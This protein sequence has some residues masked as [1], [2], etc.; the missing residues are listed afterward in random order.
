[1][2]ILYQALIAIPSLFKSDLATSRK[3]LV[4][5]W[6][7]CILVA[8]LFAPITKQNRIYCAGY[9][10]EGFDLYTLRFLFEETFLRQE[11]NVRITKNQAVCL[12]IGANIG[13][14]SLYLTWLYPDMQILAIEPDPDTF[15][16]L[17]KNI[18]HN[19]LKNVTAVH[20]A[21]SDT[22]GELV[23]YVHPHIKG[24]LKMSTYARKGMTKEVRVP[25]RRLSDILTEQKITAI[26]FAKIDI[27]GAEWQ[28]LEDLT[29]TGWLPKINQAVI[30]YHHMM[31][32]HES[33]LGAFL[34]PFEAVGFKYQLNTKSLPYNTAPLFQD[35]LIYFYQSA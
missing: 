3:L 13:M 14:V 34:A 35:V 18:A 15:A 8:L 31:G 1:M 7:L 24:S 6:Y 32:T 9:V 27:E 25:A 30:E 20:C 19:Q 33:A 26:D 17:E 16:V 10:I 4:L 11:Y 29:K 12:D 22:E 21:V 28:V 23:F 5:W 2:S